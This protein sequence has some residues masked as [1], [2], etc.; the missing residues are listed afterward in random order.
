MSPPDGAKVPFELWIHS[1]PRDAYW[2]STDRDTIGCYT[3]LLQRAVV[4]GHDHYKETR[5]TESPEASLEPE[6]P[7]S[8]WTSEPTVLYADAAQ[9]LSHN[10]RIEEDEE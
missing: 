9:T 8:S 4:L 3:G 1:H 5:H 6:G 10:G 7:L 2:S